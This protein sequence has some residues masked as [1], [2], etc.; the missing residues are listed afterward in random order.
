MV[1]ETFS[2]YSPSGT[3][4]YRAPTICKKKNNL[5][6]NEEKYSNICLKIP[7]DKYCYLITSSA[8]TCKTT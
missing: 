3:G 7:Y 8:L 4:S 2:E 1:N 5:Q 6:L